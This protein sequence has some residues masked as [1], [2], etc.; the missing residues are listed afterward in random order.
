M[1]ELT[2]DIIDRLVFCRYLLRQAEIQKDKGRPF[3]SSAVLLLHDLVECFLQI[4]MEVQLPED[5]KGTN[6]I[7]LSVVEKLNKKLVDL[8][9]API[10]SA[11]IKKLNEL[12][13][14]LKHASIFVD[15]G[16]IENLFNSTIQFLSLYSTLFF[17]KDIN[18]LSVGHLIKNERIREFVSKAESAFQASDLENTMI[19][20]AQAYYELGHSE[21][22][23]HG[24]MRENLLGP[25][26]TPN[27]EHQARVRSASFGSSPLD[28]GARD[29]FKAVGEDFRKVYEKIFEI[30]KAI[31]YKIDY[32]NFMRFKAQLPHIV[33]TSS[34]DKG[35]GYLTPKGDFLKDKKYTVKVV[36]FCK[37]FLVDIVLKMGA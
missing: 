29:G 20:I 25:E 19:Y 33:V 21:L 11:Y 32:L 3:S 1:V 6:D 9:R 23:V 28:S 4:A 36:T 35:L 27:Y 26:R 18:E 8:N 12:R 17:D 15:Q 10:P 31:I 5:R 7:L 22:V 37:D 16:E 24:S 34:K 14:Q 2:K 13:K 30:E